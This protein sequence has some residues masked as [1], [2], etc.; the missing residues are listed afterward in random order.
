[1][2]YVDTRVWLPDDLLL[3]G[4]KLSM[5][6]SLEARVPFLDVEFLEFVETIPSNL[7]L[8]GM[9]GKYI[10]K[11]A[12]AKWFPRRIIRRK[13]KG[14]ATPMDQWLQNGLTGY[15]RESLLDGSSASREYFREGV[16]ERMI[17]E[18]ASGRVNYQR[19]IFAL[20]TF[21]IW[22]RIFLDRS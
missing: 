16:V 4:D 12:M 20:L 18:H 19:Q 14:F 8:R 13:K 15:V 9:T 3:Y 11:K 7:K 6:H 5:A 22:S 10:H 2:L 17:D 21:E 1:M